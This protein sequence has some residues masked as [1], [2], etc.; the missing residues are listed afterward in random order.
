[1]LIDDYTSI[2]SWQA[3]RD[4]YRHVVLTSIL[5]K[6]PVSWAYC[7]APESYPGSYGSVIDIQSNLLYLAFVI[8]QLYTVA[9]LKIPS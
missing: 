1:M 4:R 3:C 7:D 5:V 8:L 6:A 9:E 2:L